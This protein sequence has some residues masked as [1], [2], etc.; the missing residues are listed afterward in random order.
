MVADL[1]EVVV[2]VDT[3]RDRHVLVLVDAR[4]GALIAGAEV[5]ADRAGYREALRVAGEAAGSR[6]WAIEG[7][8]SYG[9]GLARFLLGEGERV[10]EV[11]R[12]LR[13]RG[14]DGRFKD[15]GLDALR[16]ARA[17]VAGRAAGEPRAAGAREGLRVLLVAREAAVDERR[18]GLNQLRALVV[19]APDD[20]R[21]SL[22]R[23]PRAALV[24]RCLRLRPGSASGPERRAI[25]L[26]L[27][28]CARRVRLADREAHALE[29]EL[30]QRVRSSC[31]WLLD[32][33]GVGPISAAQLLVAWSHPG[34]IRSEAAFAR[35]A[36]VA[37]I[38]ASS[39]KHI[40][41]RLDRGGDRRLN[42][43]LHTIVLSRRQHDPATIAYI[44]RR[45]TEGKTP[46]EAI[47]CLK[48]FL[49]R[50]LYR[51]LETMPSLA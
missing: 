41:Y 19:T 36:G 48:R 43:A 11:E 45:Q 27:R 15:D 18:N 13:S 35:L 10:W 16:A 25:L 39:G 3:H 12:P 30:D 32:L 47:R 4:S 22:A 26:A 44:E 1:V 31:P 50:S 34:R 23:L 38:P 2:G 40:R 46:R 37:P 51:K 24:A 6:V 42:R 9:A 14:R 8:G 21:E 49:A 29:R 7:C 28:S 33:A 17:L 5:A 20:V